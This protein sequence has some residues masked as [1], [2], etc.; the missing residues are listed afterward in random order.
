MAKIGVWFSTTKSPKSPQFSYFQVACHILL[1][2]SWRELQ[3]GFRPHLHQRSACKV[4]SPQSRASPN[5]GNFETP[6]WEFSR[7][8][9]IWMPVP[10]PNI[11]YT[12][13]GKVVASP[14]SR[15]W[16]VFWVRVCPWFVYAP[17]VLQLCT[18]QLVVWF[19]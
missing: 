6:T 4:T 11:E 3:L 5:F 19:V 9:A 14:K 15:S 7:Q 10:W 1:K 8:N 13:R 16:W 17:K 18:N 2:S 12:I